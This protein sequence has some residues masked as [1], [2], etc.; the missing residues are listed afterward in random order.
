MSCVI[1]ASPRKRAGAR[2]K[3]QMRVMEEAATVADAAYPELDELI[4]QLYTD[5]QQSS[6]AASKGPSDNTDDEADFTTEMVPD[7]EVTLK[8]K[9]TTNLKPTEVIISISRK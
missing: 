8:L 9:P 2:V 7:T 3:K 4:K 6:H 1:Q 5:M